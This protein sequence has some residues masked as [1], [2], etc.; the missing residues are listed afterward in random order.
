MPSPKKGLGSKGL[1]IEALINNEINHFHSVTPIHIKEGI[2][3]IDIN[4]IEP[5]S[6]QP[7][8]KF[9]EQA[10]EELAESIKS[11]G[12][13][14]PVL[15]KKVEDYYVLVA[16]ERRWRAAKIAGVQK[17]PAIIKD[18]DEST[19]FE[20]ALVENLQR[21]NLN[22]I[23]EAKSYK[24]LAEEFHMSQEQIAEKVGK[25]RSV[26][27][28]SLRLLN[29]DIRVQNFVSENKLSN[30]HARA[31]LSVSDKNLQ[32]ELAEK[33]IEDSL[34]VREIETLVKL[35]Q[36]KKETVKKEK[37]EENYTIFPIQEYKKI[38]DDLKTVLGTK[39]KLSSN[40]N[41]GKIEIEYYSNEDL[42]RLVEKIKGIQN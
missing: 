3:D 16:G 27:A 5:S 17:I 23:E 9:E 19:A 10:L 29:L 28:N 1:G 18:Y 35:E 33:I 22:P 11:Y 14:Q 2:I 31:L 36:E 30:G 37:K 25:S 41:K 8:R 39:V 15:L 24:K 32:F 20:I 38:E 34:S 4:K 12:V 26:I 6:Q 7:R 40:K 21:E 13:I 42:D